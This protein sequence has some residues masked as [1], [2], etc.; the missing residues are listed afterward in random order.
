MKKS[1]GSAQ[2]EK[3][4][5]SKVWAATH[6]FNLLVAYF[7]EI[8]VYESTMFFDKMFCFFLKEVQRVFFVKINSFSNIYDLN[9]KVL[10]WFKRKQ[11]NFV[12]I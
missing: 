12:N 6:I 5:F 9:A 1:E 10:P 4:Y 3:V 11:E 2:S 8:R 7:H